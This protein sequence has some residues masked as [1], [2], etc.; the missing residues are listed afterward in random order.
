[1]AC[2]APFRRANLQADLPLRTLPDLGSLPEMGT[3]ARQT[4]ILTAETVVRHAGA[5]LVG[6][7]SL[8]Q[9]QGR[10]AQ[11]K[12]HRCYVMPLQFPIAHPIRAILAANRCDRPIQLIA[13]A[14]RF[15]LA[16]AWRA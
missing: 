10:P 14:P 9:R 16:A 1:M 12:L 3:S 8:L 7:S 5:A 11:D 4:L 2:I 15:H 6:A 13:S